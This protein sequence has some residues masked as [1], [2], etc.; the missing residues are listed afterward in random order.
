[1]KE[2][3]DEPCGG[4]FSDRG[5][6]H[7]VLQMGYYWP[8]IFKDAKKYVEACNRCQRMGR[9]GQDDKI[10]LQDQVVEEPFK[11]WAL[12]FFSPFNPK[13]NH[14]AYILVAKNYMTKWVEVVAFPN[15]IEEAVIK[16]LF[17]L[18]VCY[19]LPREV[20]IDRG[21]QFTAHKIMSTL[22]NYHIKHRVTSPYHPREK[23]Q[24]ESTNKFL[25]AI[26]KKTVSTNCQNWVAKL[27]NSLWSYRT[28]WSN[29]TGY[30]PYHLVF[31]KEPIFPIEFEI[32]TLRMAQEIGLDL[33]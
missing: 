24:V 5:T 30:S 17:E 28:T 15:A 32:K 14:K 25:E 26:L 6:G 8:S 13:S 29:T 18:F 21:S 16:F 4:K 7:K 33:T 12:D 9:L 10:P 27:P 23:G 1:L 3:H 20:I 11:R 19:G 31:G 2:G 22:R